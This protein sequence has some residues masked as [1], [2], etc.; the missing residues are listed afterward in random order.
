MR[1]ALSQAVVVSYLGKIG[2]LAT[3]DLL[4][5]DSFET[6]GRYSLALGL[7]NAYML[8]ASLKARVLVMFDSDEAE[9]RYLAV[10]HLVVVAGLAAL[11]LSLVS[12]QG[13]SVLTIGLLIA[14]SRFTEN[15][16]DAVVGHLQANQ[17]V[18]QSLYLQIGRNVTIAF[19]YA[20]IF[21]GLSLEAVL[22]LELAAGAVWGS[23][24][25]RGVASER[26]DIRQ[27]SPVLWGAGALSAA[28]L[29]NG[30]IRVVVLRRLLSVGTEEAAITVSLALTSLALTGRLVSSFGLYFQ[31]RVERAFE[32][33]THLRL[34]FPT[35]AGI[36]AGTY[37][38]RLGTNSLLLLAVILI[39]VNSLTLLVK[40]S[41]ML[42]EELKGLIAVHAVDLAFIVLIS[43]MVWSATDGLIALVASQVL[44]Y[45][46][47]AM[48]W[49]RGVRND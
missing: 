44:R 38:V 1:F 29:L 23:M 5:N 27:Y 43:Q 31:D 8:A 15:Q 33:L 20:S 49:R 39:V 32:T 6:L 16:A 42:R 37:A 25:W 35:L 11:A 36:A 46:L 3:F 9:E 22:L 40:Q 2:L 10:R 34:V 41:I 48:T 18:P 26:L 13:T 7:V 30:L 4:R 45:A 14:A 47:F 24:F 12:L 17:K 21:L 19:A 28:A